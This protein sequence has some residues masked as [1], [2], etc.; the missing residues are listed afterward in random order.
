MELEVGDVVLCTVERI[1]KTI[2]FVNIEGGGEG[3]IIMSEIAPGRIRNIRD[4]VVPKK[5]IACKVLRISGN[6][7][8]L[9]LRRVTKKEQKEVK[10]A[11]KQEKSY[12]SILKSILKDKSEK[13][14]EEIEKSGKVYA[15]LQEAKENSKKLEK[16]VGKKNSEKILEILQAQ[17]TKKA[18][19]K[20]EFSLTTTNP[21]GIDL[22]KK[23]ISNTKDVDIRYLSA[24]KY[25]IQAEASEIKQADNKI[26]QATEAISEQSKKKGLD[27]NIKEK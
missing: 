3:S 12:K 11:S 2:V 27:F 22:I 26:K 7:I 13:I 20:K 16:L 10:E 25:T 14:I 1:A 8:D 21:E 15:F 19:L 5:Q 18:V 17:K 6:R 4:Y 23:I 9:S 24:G